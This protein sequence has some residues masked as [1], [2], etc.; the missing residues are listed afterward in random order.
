MCALCP[1]L[2]AVV[3]ARHLILRVDKSLAAAADAANL[4]ETLRVLRPLLQYAGMPCF[5][6]FQKDFRDPNSQVGG[7]ACIFGPPNAPKTNEPTRLQTPP[8]YSGSTSCHVF[9][10]YSPYRCRVGSGAF[11]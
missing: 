1:L 3:H 9:R 5:P 11:A 7:R 10:A 2:Y 4:F 8:E 6:G